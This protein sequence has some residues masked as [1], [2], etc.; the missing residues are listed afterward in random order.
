VKTKNPVPK[1][2]IF[3]CMRELNALR[4]CA[5]VHMGQVVCPNVCG[6][7]VD[8]IATKTVEAK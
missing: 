4:L 8:V 5:P 7:G 2:L 3:D 1:K 6:T